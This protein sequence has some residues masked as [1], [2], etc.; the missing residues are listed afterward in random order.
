MLGVG[1][2]SKVEV[3]HLRAV[4]SSEVSSKVEEGGRGVRGSSQTQLVH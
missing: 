2:V 3:A 1:G 4:S